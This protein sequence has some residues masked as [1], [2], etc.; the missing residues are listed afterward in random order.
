MSYETADSQKQE[1]R[2][3]LERNGIVSQLT[4][5]LVGLYEEPVRPTSATEYIKKYL[6][7]PQGVDIEELTAENEELKKANVELEARVA[8]L[9]QQ[10]L[11]MQEDQGEA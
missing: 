2:R 8:A 9:E 4:R 7:G 10:F 5:V 11:E 6:G 3:Y 1:F